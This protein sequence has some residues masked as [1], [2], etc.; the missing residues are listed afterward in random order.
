MQ[1]DPPSTPQGLDALA[2]F[3]LLVCRGL[4]LWLLIPV[5]FVVWLTWLGPHYRVG[6]GATLGWADWNMV[7]MLSRLLI[8]REARGPALARLVPARD[9]RGTLHRIDLLA[10]W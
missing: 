5:T 8:P 9:I 2:T 3:L 6:L 1:D 10:L 7:V 4:L